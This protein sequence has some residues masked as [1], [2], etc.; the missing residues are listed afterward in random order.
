MMVPERSGLVNTFA[1]QEF[2]S[3][4][5]EPY[6]A[7][8]GAA[9]LQ[10][11]RYGGWL[12]PSLRLAIEEQGSATVHAR[13]ATGHYDPVLPATPLREGRLVLHLDATSTTLAGWSTNATLDAGAARDRLH[14]PGNLRETYATALFNGDATRDVANGTLALS[15]IGGVLGN[16]PV[17]PQQAQ[18]TLGGPISAPG[19]DF[20]RFQGPRAAAARVEWR[21]HV[22]FVRVPLGAWGTAPGTATL[23]PFVHTAWIDGAGW[24]PSVGVGA[25]TIFDLLRF[26]VARGLRDGRWSFY[27]DVSKDFWR[28][29]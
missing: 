28:V 11:P 20:A 23:A 10:L 2:G 14:A 25:L 17:L 12:R 22:P 5:T 15:L 29:L 24:R 16:A 9:E 26:D 19:Y 6:T 7:R 21:V 1:A 3:D 18:F 13:P 8:G 4:Y 27:F